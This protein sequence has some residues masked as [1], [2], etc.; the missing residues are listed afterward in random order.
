MAVSLARYILHKVRGTGV[1]ATQCMDLQGLRAFTENTKYLLLHSSSLSHNE[2]QVTV[3]TL[4]HS[5]QLATYIDWDRSGNSVSH[6][7]SNIL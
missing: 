6:R 7:P 3:N 2:T 1:L 4:R 5:P